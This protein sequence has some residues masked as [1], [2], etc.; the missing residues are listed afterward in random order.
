[1][2]T[3]LLSSAALAAIWFA[4]TPPSYHEI[5]GPRLLGPPPEAVRDADVGD[6]ITKHAVTLVD[7]IPGHD[8]VLPMPDGETALISGRDEWIWRVNFVE[9]TA[10]KLAYAPVSPTG[11]RLAPDDPNRA[12]F[13][14][15]RLDFNA[16]ANSPGLYALDI[17][18]AAFTPLAIRVPVTGTLRDDSLEVPNAKTPS[19]VEVYP[20][21][22]NETPLDELD[23]S[24]SRTL[25]FCN[26]LAVS[27]DGRYVFLTEPFSHER[28]SSGLGAFAEGITLARNGRVWRYD[29]ERKTI[30]LVVENIV[31]ADGVLIEHDDAGAVAGLLISETTNFRIGRA[32]LSGAQAGRYDV[33]WDNLPDLPDGLDRDAEGRIWVGMIK[34]RTPLMNWIHANPWIKPL[35]LRIPPSWLPPA[36]STGFMVLSS[37]ASDVLAYS[38]HDGSKLLDIAVAAPADDRVFLSSF[39]ARNQGVH[40][41]PMSAVFDE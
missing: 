38:R 17:Q 10:E 40:F 20:R 26:D 22:L 37:D 31:F 41:L 12:Y 5:P 35:L 1:M 28:A 23:D 33:L 25:Q 16:Y 15:A 21:P 36:K 9:N 19:G 13:C 3:L 29:V 30:G 7:Q 39:F 34:E 14:M 24:N 32:H 6:V 8:E 11:A 18:A 27:R 4:T 2:R